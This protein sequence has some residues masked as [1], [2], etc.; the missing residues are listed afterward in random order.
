MDVLVVLFIVD[1]LYI[2]NLVFA[3]LDEP[4]LCTSACTAIVDIEVLAAPLCGTRWVVDL[5]LWQLGRLPLSRTAAS[6]GMLPGP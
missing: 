1:L 3:S 5:C 2:H 6:L 4:A